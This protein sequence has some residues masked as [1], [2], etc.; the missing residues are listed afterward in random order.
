MGAWAGP[1]DSLARLGSTALPAKA[2][3]A[4]SYEL[5]LNALGRHAPIHNDHMNTMME[6]QTDSNKHVTVE[7]KKI[8]RN[9][10]PDVTGMGLKDAIYILENNGLNV[11]VQ[12]KGKVRQ[13]SLAPGT[14]IIKG[15]NITLQLS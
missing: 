8:Y 10:V 14:R 9:I 5:M 11:D 2:A 13:Q 1:L 6:M 12:G 7:A 4:R 15:Q 3:T